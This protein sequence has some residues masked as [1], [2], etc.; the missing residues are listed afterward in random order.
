MKRLI[1]IAYS[2]KLF[3]SVTLFIHSICHLKAQQ[4]GD[5]GLEFDNTKNDPNYPFMIEWQNA[6]VEGGVPNRSSNLT[7]ASISPTNSDG[8]QQAINNANTQNKPFVI[9]LKKGTYTID[10]PIRMRSNIILRGEDKNEVKLNVSIRSN[11]NRT[12]TSIAFNNITKAALEDLTF[13]YMPPQPIMLYDDTNVPRNTFCGDRCFN[14]NPE[15]I[16]N[17][18][19]S[20]VKMDGATTNCWVENCNFKNSGT[21]PIE[22][23]ANHNTFRNN[24]VDGAFNRGG[25]GNAYYDITGD[26]NLITN[27]RVRRIRHF[28]IQLGAKYNVVIGC[29]LEVDV[30]FHNRDDGFNLVENNIIKSERWRSWGAFASGATRFGHDKPG[31]NNIIFNNNTSGRGNSV[32]FSTDQKVFVFDQFM[33]PR[34]LRNTPPLGNTFYPIILESEANLSTEEFLDVNKKITIYPN[35]VTMTSLVTINNLKGESISLIDSAGNI[36]K[37]ISIPSSNYKLDTS[38]LVTGIYFIKNNYST[39]KLIIQ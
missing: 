27:E 10:K 38:N 1:K 16:N 7:K 19:V 37:T 4:I 25:G 5:P 8:I 29:N 15:G 31:S 20:F 28:A 9:L 30:N 39:I 22:I 18:Y 34:L 36:L 32:N 12:I 21:D 3:L 11:G 23:K 6:G 33:E 26:Y 13:E 14:N 24:F 17:M 2:I 35:P